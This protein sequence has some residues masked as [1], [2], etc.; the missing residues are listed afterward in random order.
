MLLIGEPMADSIQS[1]LGQNLLSAVDSA[2]NPHWLG[3]YT[4]IQSL[5]RLFI[6]DVLE[7]YGKEEFPTLVDQK[8][9]SLAKVFLGD[10]K[11]YPGP[12]WNQ[13]GEVDVYLARVEG[14]DSKDPI[15][16][17]AGALI[18][19]IVEILELNHTIQQE[20]ALDEQ[21]QWTA[22]EIVRSYAFK[23]MGLPQGGYTQLEYNQKVAPSPFLDRK[24]D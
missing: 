16:R 7:N 4:T 2:N 19:M 11:R 8:A 6:K 5:L 10:N 13:P 1:V 21:W 9:R 20:Q 24:R 12:T 18:N 3:S 15:E 14:I 22:S 17:V 23:I